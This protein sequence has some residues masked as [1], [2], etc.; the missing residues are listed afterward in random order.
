MPKAIAK[1]LIQK[2]RSIRSI[3]HKQTLADRNGTVPLRPARSESVSVL[4]YAAYAI[5]TVAFLLCKAPEP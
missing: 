3:F 2:A 5:R 4:K 1:Q